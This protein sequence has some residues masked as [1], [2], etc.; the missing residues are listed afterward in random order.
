LV[1]CRD[2]DDKQQPGSSEVRYLRRGTP[3]HPELFADFENQISARPAGSS[4]RKTPATKGSREPSPLGSPGSSRDLSGWPFPIGPG[5]LAFTTASRCWIPSSGRGH[6]KAIGCHSPQKSCTTGAFGIRIPVGSPPA[7]M[8]A[9]CETSSRIAPTP[10]SRTRPGRLASF[11]ATWGL[12]PYEAASSCRTDWPDGFPMCDQ[13]GA[14][15]WAKLC[16][17]CRGNVIEIEGSCATHSL[18]VRCF[19]PML[20][21]DG[22]I[23][24]VRHLLSWIKWLVAPARGSW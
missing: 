20:E 19:C 4:T 17:H 12:R 14:V 21:G 9:S 3:I 10:R 2:F 6:S 24:L 1:H 16:P 8:A 11:P 22:I 23:V 5:T 7:S 13:D 15:I 18:C